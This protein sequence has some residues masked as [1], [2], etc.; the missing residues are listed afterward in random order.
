MAKKRNFIPRKRPTVDPGVRKIYKKLR[1]N[2]KLKKL[3]KAFA[4]F[5]AFS[6]GNSNSLEEF[7]LDEGGTP[8]NQPVAVTK[9]KVRK[10]P[11]AISE[12]E[13]PEHYWLEWVIT[14]VS[15]WGPL[16]NSYEQE[17]EGAGV[18]H[19]V[20]YDFSKKF[21]LFIYRWEFHR[22]FIALPNFKLNKT[23][24]PDSLDLIDDLLKMFREEEDQIQLIMQGLNTDEVCSVYTGED[25]PPEYEY[26]QFMPEDFQK[27]YKVILNKCN[28]LIWIL[29]FI[30]Q[31]LSK[32]SLGQTPPIASLVEE[33]NNKESRFSGLDDFAIAVIY[34]VINSHSP[35]KLSEILIAVEKEFDVTLERESDKDETKARKRKIK[36]NRLG[37]LLKFLKRRGI[38]YVTDGERRCHIHDSQKEQF[39]ASISTN[40]L[41]L[42]KKKADL[43]IF[44]K[45]Q[46]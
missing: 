23:D 43:I 32:S 33:W 1:G 34:V 15:T 35:L 41:K 22:K 2:K 46:A 37:E 38:M 16:L 26:G 20:G 10:S 14:L 28:K 30:V 44:S 24:L 12:P 13:K 45:V 29:S 21:K 4:R 42:P 3:R 39:K 19:K 7:P 18:V 8:E 40:Q 11:F 31:I 25:T 6:G 36:V 5:I 9:K 17:F 27:T